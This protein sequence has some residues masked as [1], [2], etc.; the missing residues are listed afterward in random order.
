MDPN[1]VIGVWASAS[2]QKIRVLNDNGTES[3]LGSWVQ[4]SRLGM[5]LTNEA[6]IP[7]GKKD[8]WN[9][10]TPYEDLAKIKYFWEIF[11]PARTGTVY[12]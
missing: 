5:P 8:L 1:Y 2:R 11:L 12:G 7:I 6:V 10:M 3:H 4:V 9:S